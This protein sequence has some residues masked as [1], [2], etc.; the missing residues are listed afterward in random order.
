M[1]GD[2]KGTVYQKK[3]N[4]TS[5]TGLERTTSKYYFSVIL[6]VLRI[7]N[8]IRIRKDPKLLAGTE[9]NISDPDS[10]PDPK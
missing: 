3:S 8:R 7:R 1:S 6:A 5:Y 9:I 4:S 10:N 2:F